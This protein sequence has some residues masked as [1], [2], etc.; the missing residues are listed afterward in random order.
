MQNV[1]KKQ[2]ATVTTALL[3][4]SLLIAP[5]SLKALGISPSLSAG[6]AALRHVA[7]IFAD[8]YQPVNALETLAVNFADEGSPSNDA[9]PQT[10]GLL[11]SAQPFEWQALE[12]EL[13]DAPAVSGQVPAAEMAV[14]AAPTA[15]RCA[16]SL[17]PAPRAP[18]A[19]PVVA[20]IVIPVEEIR[21]QAFQAAESAKAIVPVR[22]EVVR[23]FEHEM[24]KYRVTFSEATRI[25]PRDFKLLLK[26]KPPVSPAVTSCAFSK[27]LSPEQVKRP[28][29]AWSFTTE[30]VAESP[31]KSE[32]E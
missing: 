18:L 13:N 11:A 2:N 23:R 4:A 29:T 6:V 8:S 20:N 30:P 32:L 22:R 25:A 24:T 5:L 3:F 10:D 27:P 21:A 26:V 14:A 9:E 17:R 28:R 19:A 7:G 16:K 12:V 15:R 1:A 31:E